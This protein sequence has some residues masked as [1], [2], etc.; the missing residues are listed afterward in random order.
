MNIN[1]GYTG[2]KV[3][4]NAQVSLA[5]KIVRLTSMLS[6]LTTQEDTQNKQF[7]PKVYQNKQRVQT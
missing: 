5:E 2:K 7:K 3:T 1:D 6:K 4:F